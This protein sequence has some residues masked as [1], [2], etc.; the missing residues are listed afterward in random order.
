MQQSRKTH[1]VCQPLPGKRTNVGSME[2]FVNA[3]DIML[4]RQK[5]CSFKSLSTVNYVDSTEASLLLPKT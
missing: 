1:L 5:K 4:F 2:Q 3:P